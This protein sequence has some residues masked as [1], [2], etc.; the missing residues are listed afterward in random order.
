MFGY[1]GRGFGTKIRAVW[2]EGGGW[3][4]TG[5]IVGAVLGGGEVRGKN[6]NFRGE[7]DGVKGEV[8]MGGWPSEKR[9]T[10]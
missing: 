5:N 10:R 3:G 2:K 8:E 6:S 9:G 4:L 1:G 7:G